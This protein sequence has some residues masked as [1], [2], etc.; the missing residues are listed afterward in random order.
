M[1][2]SG[3]LWGGG[4]AERRRVRTG[5]CVSDPRSALRHAARGVKISGLKKLHLNMYFW[6][7]PRFFAEM[8]SARGETLI[9]NHAPFL[10]LSC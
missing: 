3:V 10:G 8:R 5:V 2:P 9:T 4:E 7:L 6:L 1:P